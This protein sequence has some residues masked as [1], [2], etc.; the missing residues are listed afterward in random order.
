MKA[1]TFTAQGTTSFTEEPEPTPGPDDLL[2]K[3]MYSGLSN[4]TERSFLM[5]G[6]YGGQKWPNRIAYLLV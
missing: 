4:G 2:L 5:G 3:T 1:I 6:P